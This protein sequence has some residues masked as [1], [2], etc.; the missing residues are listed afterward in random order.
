MSH[1]IDWS[2]V[3]IDEAGRIHFAVE[4]SGRMALFSTAISGTHGEL[5]SHLAPPPGAIVGALKQIY[6]KPTFKVRVDEIRI[7]NRI[8]TEKVGVTLKHYGAGPNDLATYLYLR[9]VRYQVLA[10]LEWNMNLSKYAE[11]RDADKH[12]AI[13]CDVLKNKGSRR[14][15]TLGPTECNAEVRPL[16][17][18]PG[19]YEDSYGVY[20]EGASFYDSIPEMDFGVMQHSFVYPSEGY[21]E[22]TRQ[23]NALTVHFWHP[24]MRNSRIKCILPEE[25]PDRKVVYR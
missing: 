15:V 18:V 19:K 20:G 4:L 22:E 10:H 1:K 7:M 9:D 8:A 2:L 6:W 5:A 11:D 13:L 3:N 24:V 21:D 17:P 25:C 12:A 16:H 14:P 23:P